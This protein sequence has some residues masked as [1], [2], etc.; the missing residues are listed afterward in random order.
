MPSRTTKTAIL[1]VLAGFDLILIVVEKLAEALEMHDFSRTEKLDDFVYIGVV[2]EPQ[3]VVVGR[4]GFLLCREVF[5][6]VCDR[7][8][9]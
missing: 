2:G 6:K 7:V 1:S 8:G 4:A 9:F 5:N 3:N